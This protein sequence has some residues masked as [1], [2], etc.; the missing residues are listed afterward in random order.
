MLI[1]RLMA[2]V[3]ALGCLGPSELP[4]TAL[5]ERAS[6][7]GR[8]GRIAL[9]H[10]KVSLARRELRAAML[11]Q[12]ALGAT[13]A[14]LADGFALTF[15]EADIAHDLDRAGAV[16]QELATFARDN[17]ED[18]AALA[19]HGAL[20]AYKADEPR[21]ALALLSR[22][23]TEPSASLP[24]SLVRAM[25][26][27]HGSVLG[28]LGCFTEARA[29]ATEVIGMS[30]SLGP[31]EQS[32]AYSNRGW[33]AMLAQLS[34]VETESKVP[35][36]HGDFLT[37]LAAAE[38]CADPRRLGHAT[39]NV[40]LSLL[41]ELHD[42]PAA[43]HMLQRF[44]ALA[45][46]DE[47]D[48]RGWAQQTRGRI[49]L[50]K[51]QLDAAHDAFEREL[52]LAAA[53]GGDAAA[54]RALVGLG[55]EQSARGDFEQALHHFQAAQTHLTRLSVLT[56]VS[57]GHDAFFAQGEQAARGAVH[58]LAALGRMDEAE[59][60]ARAA[61][62]WSTAQAGIAGRIEALTH[63]RRRSLRA[64]LRSYRALR[65]ALDRESQDDWRLSS[66]ALTRLAEH[67]ASKQAALHRA[68][69][70]AHA[71]A[72]PVALAKAQ[73]VVPVGTLQLTFYPSMPD[74]RDRAWWMFVRDTAG[75]RKIDLPGASLDPLPILR[76]Q[77]LPLLQHAGAPWRRIELYIHPAFPRAD[78]H[79]LKLDE[80]VLGAR[81][82]VVYGQGLTPLPES[83]LKTAPAEQAAHGLLVLDPTH[84]L[85]NIEREGELVSRALRENGL[86]VLSRAGELATRAQLVVDL[87]SVSYLH[88]AGHARSQTESSAGPVLALAGGESLSAFDVLS[89]ERVPPRV[90]L[91]AC[92][93][94]ASD[95]ASPSLARAFLAQGSLEVMAPTR[96][97]ADEDAARVM[98]AL[99]AE[100]PRA[101]SLAEAFRR[102]VVRLEA[103]PK[104]PD[105]AAFRILVR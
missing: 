41:I 71:L 62:A 74:G 92:R 78:L 30:A 9:G 57:T 6:A 75:V 4:T 98:E 38:R 44:E 72:A 46:T 80:R 67:R 32:D 105:W 59:L 99:Y 3:C 11:A 22:A 33:L 61:L 13:A 89:L 20:I 53:S 16:L 63:E 54:Y 27:L 51:G 86:S 25:R 42:V 97:I 73:R 95:S 7:H 66:E 64:S 68:L 8:L 19:H 39:I 36:A 17:P 34:D 96:A 24:A 50:A 91:S 76:R 18:R 104:P 14:A 15:L 87:S 83:P 79:A 1:R 10:G 21:R 5:A 60:A 94:G 85:A 81:A 65:E 23:R 52:A 82:E 43:E 101:R 102:A 93:A 100:L 58:S 84:T 47:P 26:T 29:L 35:A 88:F 55:H 12:R 37:E 28:S 40:A 103:Q 2:W 70:A 45:L 90:V 31:C 49:L 48:L 56:P 77:L 69:D